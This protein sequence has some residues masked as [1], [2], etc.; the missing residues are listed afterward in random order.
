MLPIPR[1]TL[2][3]SIT[4]ELKCLFF[5][6][7]SKLNE[8][9]IINEFEGEFA[10]YNGSKLCKYLEILSNYLNTTNHTPFSFSLY[11]DLE[12]DP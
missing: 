7:F 11:L 3:H 1:G 4:F 5:S 2:Y 9:K 8:K 12:W 6:F 10:K